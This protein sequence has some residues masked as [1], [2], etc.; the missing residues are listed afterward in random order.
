MTIL[1]LAIR[2][3]RGAGIRTWL[4]AVALSF[5]FVAIIF[6]QG[7]LQ[8]MNKQAEDSS[9]AFEF[10]GGQYWQEHYDPFDPL[11]LVDAHAPLPPALESLAAA[12]T[13][14]PI[15][16][17]AGSIYPQ[18]RLKPVLLKGIDPAQN[19]LAIPTHALGTGSPSPF[20]SPQGGGNQMEGNED[21]PL[22]IG[23]RTAAATGL[24][25]GDYVT[26]QWRDAEGAFDA[27]DGRIVEVMNTTVMTV[28]AGQVWMPLDTLRSL[29]GMP[30]EATLVALAP[31]T[32]H[33]PAA[34]G[35]NFR[36]P[37]Y[38]MSDLRQMVKSKTVGQTIMFTVLFLLAMLAIFD[39]Q[40]LSVFR[41]RREIGMLVALG[42]TKAKVILLFTLEGALHSI[43]AA[44]LGLA[45]G[46]PLFWYLGRYGFSL[47]GGES[48]GYALGDRLYPAFTAGLILGTTLLVFV[49]TAFVAWLPTRRIARLKPTDALAGRGT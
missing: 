32:K 14:A 26:V 43:L 47:P 24:A 17:I 18:G 15:L 35:W 4:N 36:T 2:N 7:M 28:D 42:M 30:G 21:L 22:L 11:T 8:G 44:L 19:V 13:A 48:W 45:Y 29:A 3:L 39:T 10:G 33:A 27:R 37:D 25:V 31:G 6:G 12:G 20:P 16:I 41:R 34:A 9:T 40:V 23:A 1:R 5:A 38:L 49:V 46:G